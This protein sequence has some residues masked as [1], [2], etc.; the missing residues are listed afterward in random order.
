[1]ARKEKGAARG[2]KAKSQVIAA[3]CDELFPLRLWLF[4]SFVAAFSLYCLDHRIMLRM[5]LVIKSGTVIT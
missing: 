1:M 3:L 2:E 4:V 5:Q